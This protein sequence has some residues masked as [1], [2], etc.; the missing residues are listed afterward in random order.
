MQQKGLKPG[1]LILIVILLIGAAAV[2]LQWPMNQ[3]LNRRL[4]V[5]SA[6]TP[7]PTADVR[8]MLAV[9]LPPGVTPKPTV[10]LLKP[11]V[12]GDEVKK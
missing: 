1:T 9:T 8:S 11:G 3:E 12:E 2:A 4:A 7:T 5:E 6:A 10:M